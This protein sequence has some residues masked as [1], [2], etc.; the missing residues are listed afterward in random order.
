MAVQRPEENSYRGNVKKPQTFLH[1]YLLAM[2]N[3]RNLK[4]MIEF[5]E[6]DKCVGNSPHKL[7]Y[8]SKSQ[9]DH[10]KV[11]AC[12]SSSIIIQPA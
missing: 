6:L 10:I 5:C 11:Q 4:K 9:S 1:V 8:N 12:W 3:L 2:H 7:C